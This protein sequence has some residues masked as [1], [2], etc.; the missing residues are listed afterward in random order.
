MAM[1][2][3]ATVRLAS[4]ADDELPAFRRALPEHYFECRA[5]GDCAVVQGWCATFAINKVALEAYRNMPADTAGKA[6]KNC[7]PGWLPPLP[8]AVCARQRCAVVSGRP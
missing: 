8:M 4:A 7:P 2:A 3:L 5:D 6:S 1:I